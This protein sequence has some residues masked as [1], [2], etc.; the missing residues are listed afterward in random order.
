MKRIFFCFLVI[1]LA[2]FTLVKA[3]SSQPAL[4]LGTDVGFPLKNYKA[5]VGFDAKVELP[6]LQSLKLKFSAGYSALIPD[7]RVY[8]VEPVTSPVCDA[9]TISNTGSDPS[10]HFI[11]VKAGLRYYYSRYF[12]VDGD[13]GA[14]FKANYVAN[15]SFIYGFGFGVLLPFDAHNSLDFGLNFESGYKTI[16]YSSPESQL[17]VNLAYRYQF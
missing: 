14:A 13:A 17:G 11:P 10:Y 7:N 3:Q 8:T 9:C 6:L 1:N 5:N 12:Y 16:Y 15:T 4:S 2:A